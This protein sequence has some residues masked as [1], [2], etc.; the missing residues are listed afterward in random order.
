M[1]I[2]VLPPTVVNRIAAGEVIERPA[3]AVKELVEN[4]IDAGATRIDVTLRDGGRSLITVVDDGGGMSADELALAVERHATSKLPDDDLT[5]IAT[6]GFRGEA[7]PSIA[8]VGR[9]TITSRQAGSDA[10]WSL[11]VEGGAK[12]AVQPAALGPGTRVELRD[13]FY[14]TPARLKF[15]KAARTELDHVEDV[16]NRLAMAHP[17]IGFTLTDDA[18]PVLRLGAAATDLLA[19]AAAARLARLAQVMGRDFADNAL[20]LDVVRE[21]VRLTGHIGLPTLNRATAAQQYLFVNGRPVRDRLLQGAVRGAYQDF[22][23]RDRHPLVALFVELPAEEVD[24]NVHPAK[25]EVRFRDPGLVRGLIVGASRHALA[26][27]GHR[28]STTVAAAA[29]GSFRPEA[30]M[31]GRDPLWRGTWPTTS[32]PPRGVAEAAALVYAPFEGFERPQARPL[33]AREADNASAAAAA[34]FPL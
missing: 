27:A 1:P 29:L 6:L 5:H 34:S 24:I 4:A 19:D 33:E 17:A 11:A 28:A 18:R 7:L 31:P 16:I 3:S 21:G 10:A 32:A 26:G 12:G 25:A 9:L 14:A 8:A 22:L 20:Q 23:A 13:L 2:R 30:P 15:L